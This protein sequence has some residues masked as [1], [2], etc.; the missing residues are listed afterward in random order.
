[1]PF[2]PYFEQ[3][4]QILQAQHNNIVVMA[5]FVLLH[6]AVIVL[7]AAVFLGYRGQN[8]WLAVDLHP[9]KSLK[10]VAEIPNIRSHLLRRV[11]ADYA[12][13]AEK[14]APRVPLDAIISKHVLDLNYGGWRYESI[15]RWLKQLDNGLILV[16][17]ILLFIF[18]EYAVVYGIIAVA[19]FLLLKL[20]GSFLNYETARLVLTADI[21]LYV[22]R[23]VGRFFAGHVAGAVSSFKKEMA[24]AIDRLG[25]DLQYLHALEI[26]PKTLA[27]M[28]ESNDRY[29]LHHE[30]FL[31]H[32]QIIKDTQA[33]LE[34]SLHSYETTLQNL[35]QT[36]GSG[37]GT[38][39][40][41]HGQNAANA[42]AASLD[43][44]I[45]RV[46]ASNQ[47]AITRIAALIEQL[48]EQNRDVS[49][50]LRALHEHITEL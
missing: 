35:V 23:E 50:H 9:S 6:V 28:K 37:M 27:E 13:A 17:L 31:T 16:G 30:A 21:H 38:F 34:S 25:K 14:N 41:L 46:T 8:I 42:L 24:A 7:R 36:M 32:T 44:H 19:G 33:S 12:A 20:A 43:E 22:E 15:G 4:F 2:Y 39:V 1:M 5:V 40:Q 49:A 11:S 48:T 18:P 29:A 47:E 26:L 3:L 45:A 10:T